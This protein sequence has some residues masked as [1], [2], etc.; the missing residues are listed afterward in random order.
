MPPKTLALTGTERLS[1]HPISSE[2]VAVGGWPFGELIQYCCVIAVTDELHFT[3]AA[4][5]LN[6]DQSAVSRHIQ[7]LEANLG[8][9]L[10]TRGSRGVELTEAGSA[11]AARARKALRSA[12]E[13]ATVAKAIG[14]G[15]PQQLEIAYSSQVDIHALAVVR[16]VVEKS[17]SGITTR[18][19]SARADEIVER[20][21]EG[22]AHAGLALLP[23]GSDLT[24]QPLFREDLYVALPSADVATNRRS[25]R[26]PQLADFRVIWPFGSLESAV[27][28]NVM[29]L[30]REGQYAPRI[31]AEAHSASEAVGFVRE[32]L[33]ITFIKASDLHLRPKDVRFCQIADP[34]LQLETGLVCVGDQKS[35]TVERFLSVVADA[36]SVPRPTR[37]SQQRELARK[38]NGRVVS[39]EEVRSKLRG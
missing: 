24:A 38:P 1:Q 23:T 3:R 22:T 15:E 7:K 19:Q 25:I 37:L 29:N 4:Q 8:V 6:M 31:Y 33:G 34:M 28:K 35:P 14:N 26:L 16:R 11:F 39:A 36:F 10:F 5:R 17:I 20:L 32:G 9:K 27:S 12:R 21:W 30:F 13:A 2:E 18:F